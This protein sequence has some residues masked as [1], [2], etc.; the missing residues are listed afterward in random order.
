MSLT[1]ILKTRNRNHIQ[2][3]RS[4][5]RGVLMMVTAMLILPGIDAI[6]KYMSGQLSPGQLS[7]GRFVFQSIFLF[8]FV[9]AGSGFHIGRNLWI[10]IGRGCLIA[11]GTVLFFI[12]VSHMP[13]ADTMAIF[14][15]EPLI[16]TL[17]APVFLKEQVGWRRL[18]AVAAGL[19]GSLLVIQPSFNAF[20]FFALLPVFAA[21]AFAFYIILTRKL[22]RDINTFTIQFYAG[23]FGALLMSGALVVGTS[24][25]FE[26]LTFKWP[27]PTEWLWMAALAA[28]AT[29]GHLLI[30]QSVRYVGASMIAPFQY[31]EIVSA[32]TLGF[33]IF[34]DFP[35]PAVWAGIAV[36]IVAGLYVFHREQVQL[37][38]R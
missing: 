3:R 25:A 18:A 4:L 10:L 27:S 19:F 36:I 20:G 12:A 6:A 31:L 37:G 32:T 11:I 16:L 8:G 13:L 34:G 22:T 23:I 15:V 33:A 29:V 7:W 30:V 28:I 26:A 38:E 21:I 24:V 9:V 1:P 2:D 14:F 35:G 17:L 5:R